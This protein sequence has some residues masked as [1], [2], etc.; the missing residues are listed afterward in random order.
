MKRALL[1][2]ICVPLLAV[3]GCGDDAS[4]S[5]SKADAAEGTSSAG[6]STDGD[7]SGVDTGADTGTQDTGEDAGTDDSSATGTTDTGGAD[8]TSAT[9]DTGATGDTNSPEPA[10]QTV[11]TDTLEAWIDADDIVLINVHIPYAGEIPGT[12]GHVSFLETA[13]IMAALDGDKGKKA[14]LYC[15]TGPMSLK[16]THDLVSAGYYNV[17]DFPSAMV[18]WKAA[19]K[20][21][22]S[23]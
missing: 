2:L 9:G 7:T 12:D 19:G 1:T 22:T 17:Y 18:G 15:Q 14:V 3:A 5:T 8:D 16:A 21:F 4:S 23:P 11:D 13:L 20:A 10:Y 6:E